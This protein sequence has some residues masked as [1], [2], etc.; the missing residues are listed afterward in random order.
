MTENNLKA[1]M[2]KFG[3]TLEALSKAIGMTRQSLY[4]K[5]SGKTDWRLKDMVKIYQFFNQY[6][7]IELD[8]LFANYIERA[9]NEN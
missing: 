8:L 1:E 4:N 2:A 3:I 5:I 6:E 7:N 9:L